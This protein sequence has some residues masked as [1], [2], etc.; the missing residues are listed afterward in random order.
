MQL[1]SGSTNAPPAW[2]VAHSDAG[3]VWTLTE[4][5]FVGVGNLYVLGDFCTVFYI[6]SF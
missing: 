5:Y 2:H 1:S 3:G 6:P 4:D